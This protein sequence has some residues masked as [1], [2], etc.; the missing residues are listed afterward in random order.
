MSYGSPVQTGCS[1]RPSIKLFGVLCFLLVS[2]A[3]AKP[4]PEEELARSTSVEVAELEIN[5]SGVDRFLN[6]PPP[7]ELG[8]AWIPP[9]PPW[10]PP[11][12][13]READ[14]GES[15]DGGAPASPDVAESEPPASRAFALTH[16]PFRL[17]YH[18]GLVF[19]PTQDG[20][21]AIVLRV[22]RNGRVVKVESY[23]ACE[24]A[25][26]TIVCMQDAAKRIRLRPSREPETLV[27]PAVFAQSDVQRRVTPR[28]TDAYAT[29]AYLRIE[30]ARPALHA[31]DEHNGISGKSRV[32]T[33]TIGLDLD[34]NG[35]VLHAHVDPW[36][37]DQTLLGCAA[38]AMEH[39]SFP[40]PPGGSGN[41]LARISFN[42]RLGVH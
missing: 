23:G 28:S 15:E 8:Q 34:P 7:G 26:E 13:A 17:C 31:C 24:I 36:A 32:A 1:S 2:C 41:V 14:P 30:S 19:D 11:A 5:A 40:A 29:A 16:E 3:A 6:C 21:V 18:R 12:S 10:S 22:G 33:A 37:G 35:R 38:Q 25:S 42:P 39:L 27:V 20:H 4:P 9:I